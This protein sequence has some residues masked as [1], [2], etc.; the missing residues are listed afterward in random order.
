MFKVINGWTKERMKE[1]IRERNNGTKSVNNTGYCQYKRVD[2]GQKP[3]HCA[4]GCFIPDTEY[5][6]NLEGQ[7]TIPYLLVN[8]PNLA[9]FMPLDNLPMLTMQ[10][11]HDG[12]ACDVDL[13]DVL[14]NWIDENVID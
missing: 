4:V 14:C 2:V 8:F 7:G 3:N 9:R 12:A 1:T 5:D 11:L 13:R 6:E 10:R